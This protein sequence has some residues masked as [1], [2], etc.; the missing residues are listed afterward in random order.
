MHQIDVLLID[1]VKNTLKG[2]NAERNLNIFFSNMPLSDEHGVE[3]NQKEVG[4]KFG[5]TRESIR[6]TVARVLSKIKSNKNL[7]QEFDSFCKNVNDICPTSISYANKMLMDKGIIQFPCVEILIKMHKK[8]TGSAS[9]N[10][11]SSFNGLENKESDGMLS[12][13]GSYF[14]KK[15]VHNGAVSV[16][17]M[18]ERFGNV[19]SSRDSMVWV[20]ED[21]KNSSALPGG[22]YYLGE[23]GRNRLIHRLKLIL[24]SYK[25]VNI[26]MIHASICRSWRAD[27]NKEIA[28]AQQYGKYNEST[29]SPFT[30][31]VPVAVIS[32][33]INELS[34]GR[35]EGNLV[36]SG[37]FQQEKE[38]WIDKAIL[39]FMSKNDGQAREKQIE[40]FILG[41][42]SKKRFSFMQFICN[43]PLIKW[44]ERGLY[45]LIGE[46]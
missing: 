25:S 39:D 35:F 34:L 4:L 42:E 32:S 36:V 29:F 37:M 3:L 11:V 24:N 20:M 46:R 44:D 6:Q 43:S 10:I 9:I 41:K 38:K 8:I 31:V 40:K 30:Q 5:L 12:L 13:I 27:I 17:E 19:V 14:V 15:V 1:F 21:I 7:M 45:S 22:Y 23:Q 18:M 2:K 16:D 33:I 28:D 26:D